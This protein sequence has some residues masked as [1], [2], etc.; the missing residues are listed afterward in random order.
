MNSTDYQP[1]QRCRDQPIIVNTTKGQFFSNY[2]KRTSMGSN[3]C[4]WSFELA[5]SQHLS[6]KVIT[7]KK[8]DNYNF[9][10]VETSGLEPFS[11]EANSIDSISDVDN[12]KVILGTWESQPSYVV[13]FEGFY[14]NF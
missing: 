6:L 1:R 14:R 5:K 2:T 10:K 11:F 4:P 7:S 9:V 8:I 13:K 3:L 12:A